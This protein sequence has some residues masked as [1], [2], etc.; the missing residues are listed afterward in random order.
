MRE[1]QRSG[2]MKGQL[3]MHAK[4]LVIKSVFVS[5]IIYCSACQLFCSGTT[6]IISQEICT[7]QLCLSKMLLKKAFCATAA[8]RFELNLKKFLLCNFECSKL[9]FKRSLQINITSN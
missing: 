7:Y 1:L 6:N 4:L 3:F 8:A 9:I 2:V 5:S